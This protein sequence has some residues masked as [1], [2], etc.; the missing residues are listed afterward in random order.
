LGAASAIFTEAFLA[1]TAVGVK[2]TLM[3]QES[4]APRDEGQLLFWLKSLAF[5]PTMVTLVMASAVVPL[6]VK[7]VLCEGVA[8][9][10]GSLPKF[11]AKGQTW[12]P[13]TNLVMKALA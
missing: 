2:V 5:A 8:T 3:V 13:G 12:S 9:P 4:P 1:P 7:T 10:M 11:K 6:F